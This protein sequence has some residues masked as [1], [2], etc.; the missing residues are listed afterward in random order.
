MVDCKLKAEISP[1][2][3]HPHPLA[4][5]AVKTG[6]EESGKEM[7]AIW[8]KLVAKC[9]HYIVCSGY[10]DYSYGKVGRDFWAHKLQ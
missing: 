7:V 10:F 6:L 9:F 1:P 2:P 3:P 5:R 4:G 8:T